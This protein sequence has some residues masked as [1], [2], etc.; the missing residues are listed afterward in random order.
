MAP[1]GE[2]NT[3]DSPE[4]HALTP[5]DRILRLEIWRQGDRE[6]F[7]EFEETITAAVKEM[8][9]KLDVLIQR[10]ASRSGKSDVLASIFRGASGP[11]LMA[12]IAVVGFLAR[13]IF[14]LIKHP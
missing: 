4:P 12:A 3:G 9:G 1:T 14:D 7:H 2:F 8:S 11:L 5:A 13:T 6:R 10:D